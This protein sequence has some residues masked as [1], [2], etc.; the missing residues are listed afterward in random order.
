M[1]VLARVSLHLDLFLPHPLYFLL[2]VDQHLLDPQVFISQAH[3]DDLYIT[4]S[5][6]HK[7]VFLQK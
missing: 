5:A 3:N 7:V 6:L 1:L 4:V 2:L